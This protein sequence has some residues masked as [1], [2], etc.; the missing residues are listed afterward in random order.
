MS[1]KLPLSVGDII[2]TGKFKNKKETIKSFGTDLN[3]QPTINGKKMLTFRIAKLMKKK[4]S[5]ELDLDAIKES[6]FDKEQ[7]VVFIK[8]IKDVL[9]HKDEI[10]PFIK[11]NKNKK[12]R[13]KNGGT[14][15]GI[16]NWALWN[17]YELEFTPNEISKIADKI[18]RPKALSSSSKSTCSAN[19]AITNAA[20]PKPTRVAIAIMEVCPNNLPV[21]SSALVNG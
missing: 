12:F 3:G 17:G 8:N 6:I 2:L 14:I 5:E 19:R 15:L 21:K 9:K 1:I 7:R 16:L 11:K 10:L 4:E 13:T 18:N 20:L